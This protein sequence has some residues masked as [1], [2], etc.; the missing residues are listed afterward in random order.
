MKILVTGGA[1]FI[2]S[3]LCERLLEQNHSV[4][5]IDDLSTGNEENLENIIGHSKFRFIKGSILNEQ[6]MYVLIDR[7]DVIYHLAAAVGVQLIVD[8]PVRTIETNIRGTE[9]VLGIANKSKKKVLLASSSEVYG[10]GVNIPFKEDDD[11]LLGATVH[12]RWSYSCSKAIDEFLGLAYYMQFSMPVVI[13]RIFNTVGPRQT[14]KYGMVMPRFIE[15]ALTDKPITIYGD[16][17]QTRC[18]AYVADVVNAL[19]QLMEN[20]KSEGHIFNVGSNEEL[21]IESLAVKIKK[22]TASSSEI[23]YLSYEEAYGKQIDDMLR[24]VPCLKKIKEFINYEL[25]MDIDDI[26]IKIADYTKVSLKETR[27]NSRTTADTICN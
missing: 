18:F 2:G 21:S 16:G 4:D 9:I 26:L 24:R 19:I 3:Y 12:S 10:K 17:K 15:A 1:G 11:R 20:K 23:V 13:A 27:F 5:A 8:E 14:G 7:C 25:S 22:L 6:L